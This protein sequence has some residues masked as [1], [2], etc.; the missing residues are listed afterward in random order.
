MQPGERPI[1]GGVIVV[2]ESRNEVSS[3]TETL[4]HVTPHCEPVDISNYL[5]QIND[6]T[7]T[8]VDEIFCDSE[9]SV[10]VILSIL[11][12]TFESFACEL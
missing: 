1:V 8:F 4:C 9:S 12:R 6:I 5:T 10:C 2:L 7:T 3:T 11:C